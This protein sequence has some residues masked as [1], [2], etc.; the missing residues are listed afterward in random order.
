MKFRILIAFHL[1]CLSAT[2]QY[3]IDSTDTDDKEPAINWFEQKKRTWV[4]GDLAMRFGTVTYVYTSPTIGYEFYP[5]FS[6]GITG[7][8][9]LVRIRYNTGAILTEHTVGGGLFLRW[10][11]L[12]FLMFQTEF[13][14]LNTAHYDITSDLDRVNVPV[15]LLG[16]GYCGNLGDRAYYNVSLMWDFIN[17]E[18][19]PVPNFFATYPIYLRY[20]FTFYLG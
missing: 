11:P 18:N 7:I 5:K 8:Y 12:D 2:A 9:Q 14:L 16:A 3:N 13:D 1:L 6:A 19:M 20:G 17:D 4:G 15:F 10:K